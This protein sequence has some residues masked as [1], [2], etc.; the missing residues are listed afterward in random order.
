MEVQYETL[1]KVRQEILKS[2]QSKG[3]QTLKFGSET[4]RGQE[5]MKLNKYSSMY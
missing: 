1:G 3:K 2:A 5:N 4:N